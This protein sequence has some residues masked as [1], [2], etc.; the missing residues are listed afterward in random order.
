MAGVAFAAFLV[1]Y[2]CIYLEELVWLWA[3]GGITNGV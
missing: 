2:Y 1:R 3:P